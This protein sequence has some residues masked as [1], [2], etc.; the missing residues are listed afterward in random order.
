M[1]EKPNVKIEVEPQLKAELKAAGGSYRDQ[2][3]ERLINLAIGALP[4]DQKSTEMVSHAGSL[5]LVDMGC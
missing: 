3:N 5:L 2:W 4:V 1:T